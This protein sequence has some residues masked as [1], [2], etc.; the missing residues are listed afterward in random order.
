MRLCK[1]LLYMKFAEDFISVPINQTKAGR[2]ILSV[3]QIVLSGLSRLERSTGVNPESDE[4]KI[5]KCCL[6]PQLK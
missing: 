2:I 1:D 5:I 4:G 6:Y 3:Q